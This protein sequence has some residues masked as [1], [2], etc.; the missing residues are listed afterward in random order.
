MRTDTERL[1]R[2]I[3]SLVCT[4][5][6][7]AC[8]ASQS[9][10]ELALATLKATAAY[11]NE[12]DKK[13]NAERQFYEAQLGNIRS[14]LGGVLLKENLSPED[15]DNELRKTWLYGHIRTNTARA[16]R[17][18]AGKILSQDRPL[19]A[20]LMIE[21]LEKGLK[22][23]V[24]AIAQVRAKQEELTRQLVTSL[25]PVKKQKNRLSAIRKGLTTL[26]AG[27]GEGDRF[28]LALGFAKALAQEI[29]GG[30]SGN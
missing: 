19:T 30:I 24:E 10:Q 11:E 13:I 27:G 14:A 9:A 12:I 2:L 20:G 18:T 25:A 23:D 4:L 29:E 26:A 21:F 28:A 1:Q 8:T 7:A 5:G 22:E 15:R 6:M 3:L 16:G 17:L